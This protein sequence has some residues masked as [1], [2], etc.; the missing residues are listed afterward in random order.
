MDEQPNENRPNVPTWVWILGVFALILGLQLWLSGRFNGPEQISLLDAMDRVKSGEVERVV[1][2][3]GPLTATDQGKRDAHASVA[4]A[5]LEPAHVG[6]KAFGQ[7]S[8]RQADQ[9]AQ[10]GDVRHRRTRIAGP[11]PSGELDGAEVFLHRLLD[12]SMF[13]V[14]TVE[15]G[16]STGTVDFGCVAEVV[17]IADS[18]DFSS[19]DFQ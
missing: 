4:R 2:A 13:R 9:F 6:R 3:A 17:A 19:G 5:A 18:L 1:V 11:R 14:L 12:I 7:R 10:P 16:L 15:S 8:R